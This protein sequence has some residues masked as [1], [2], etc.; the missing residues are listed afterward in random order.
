M[1]R[2]PL[3]RLAQSD[4]AEIAEYVGADKPRAAERLL[5]RLLDQCRR[6]CEHPLRCPPFED[7][8]PGLRRAV[9]KPYLVFFVVDQNGVRIERI[10]HGARDLASLFADKD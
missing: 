2:L 10:I 9:C 3:S 7:L 6:V 5:Q 4:L 8:R 1:S